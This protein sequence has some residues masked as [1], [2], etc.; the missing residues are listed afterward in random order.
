[1]TS[2]H[3]ES[4]PQPLAVDAEPQAG[5]RE[6]VK[7]K[8]QDFKKAVGTSWSHLTKGIHGHSSEPPS[9]DPPPQAPN[10]RP[11]STEGLPARPLP[12]PGSM[13]SANRSRN[14]VV[15]AEPALVGGNFVSQLES[16][17]NDSEVLPNAGPRVSYPS[18]GAR[19]A[20]PPFQGRLEIRRS[21]KAKGVGVFALQPLQKD[22]IILRENAWLSC[23]HH[24][25]IFGRHRGCTVVEDWSRLDQYKRAQVK[26][27]FTEQVGDIPSMSLTS[28]EKR[29]LNNFVG[30]YAFRHDD[31]TRDRDRALI[32]LHPCK[33]NHACEQHSN[34]RV[35]QVESNNPWKITASLRRDVVK[36]EELLFPYGA[37]KT[38][39]CFQ[40]CSRLGQRARRIVWDNSFKLCELLKRFKERSH[41]GRDRQEKETHSDEQS[42]LGEQPQPEQG[43]SRPT[44]EFGTSSPASARRAAGQSAD[45]NAGNDGPSGSGFDPTLPATTLLMGLL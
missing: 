41:G 32:Y 43:S 35:D 12:T 29:R 45:Q 14:T 20:T 18:D 30:K 3:V 31:H 7:H 16:D 33:L 21:E 19:P 37:T 1:M 10:S 9:Q 22:E 24:R 23:R 17:N 13:S 44:V 34:C 15:D 40:C 38:H 36:G 28:R 8:S 26:R 6:A 5:F 2:H 27:V 25:T 4:P 11:H 39:A 42:V